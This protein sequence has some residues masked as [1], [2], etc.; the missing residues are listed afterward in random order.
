MSKKEYKRFGGQPKHFCDEHIRFFR[1]REIVIFDG[2]K[3]RRAA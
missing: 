2:R 1:R 3:K